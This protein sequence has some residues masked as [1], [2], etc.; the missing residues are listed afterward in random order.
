MRFWPPS[1][2]GIRRPPIDWALTSIRIGATLGALPAGQPRHAIATGGTAHGLLEL[3][4]FRTRHRHGSGLEVTLDELEKVAAGLLAR[5]AAR[6]GTDAG[7]DPRRVAL[8]APGVLILSAILRH[9]RLTE[10]RVVEAG[11]REGMI[12][13]AAANADGWWLDDPSPA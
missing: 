1:S 3:S 13:A 7:I 6:I 5:P 9:Y 11:L 2:K 12:R 4:R 10:F 8:L